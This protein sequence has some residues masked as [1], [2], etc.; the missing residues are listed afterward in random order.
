MIL[1]KNSTLRK[2]LRSGKLDKVGE[3]NNCEK[4]LVRWSGVQERITPMGTDCAEDIGQ[5]WK[6]VEALQKEVIELKRKQDKYENAMELFLVI[7][8]QMKNLVEKVNTMEENWKTEKKEMEISC[9]DFKQCAKH[10]KSGWESERQTLQ[11]VLE[12]LAR[13]DSERKK[14]EMEKDVVFRRCVIMNQQNREVSV[15]CTNSRPSPATKEPMEITNERTQGQKPLQIAS[16]QQPACSN[17][18]VISVCHKTVVPGAIC[19]ESQPLVRQSVSGSA[20]QV[21]PPL[22]QPSTIK[23]LLIGDISGGTGTGFC[24]KPGYRAHQLPGICVRDLTEKMKAYAI[25]DDLEVAIL[26]V[27]TRD[28]QEKRN[29][30]QI[31]GDVR[32]LLATAQLRFGDKCKVYVTNIL[33]NRGECPRDLNNNLR[34]VCRE[35]KVWC[36]DLSKMRRGV[37]GKWDWHHRIGY[38]IRKTIEEK[39]EKSLQGFW[40]RTVWKKRT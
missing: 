37:S 8:S 39:H 11:I 31:L 13:S 32:D 36:I 2:G 35:L 6:I 3:E 19:P 28:L 24:S 23:A 18:H 17:L 29:R 38:G 27:G 7:Q 5:A 22:K 15:V 30:G 26:C 14:A 34:D 16:M 4:G 20:I 33:T 1:T 25:P 21:K 10:F 40:K 9:E 12:T